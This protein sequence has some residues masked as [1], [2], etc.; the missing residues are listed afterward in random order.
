MFMRFVGSG[1]GHKAN[2][3]SQQ[4]LSASV[5]DELEPEVPNLHDNR[6]DN[7]QDNTQDQAQGEGGD[8]D[9]EEDCEEVDMDE[10]ADYGYTDDTD[11][12]SECEDD[13][14]EGN[15]SESEDGDDDKE[16]EVL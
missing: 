15:N 1:I 2:D 8:H 4:I 16:G 5:P 3:Y 11:Q 13:N 7:T 12:G 9:V 10:E 6:G 14:S